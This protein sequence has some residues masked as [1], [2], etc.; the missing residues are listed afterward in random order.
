MGYSS[1]NQEPVMDLNTSF[2]NAVQSLSVNFNKMQL[3][4]VP[5]V[6]SIMIVM[7]YLSIESKSYNNSPPLQNVTK[8]MSPHRFESSL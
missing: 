7:R 5:S 1:T 3:I 8:N 4:K 2:P 6:Q